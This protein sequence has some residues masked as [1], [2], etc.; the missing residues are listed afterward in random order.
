MEK[1]VYDLIG[2]DYNRTRTADP[3][4]VERL[5]SLLSPD[6][7]SSYLDVGCG[8]GNYTIA[9]AAKGY[10]M[11]GAEPSEVM[12]E[13]AKRKSSCVEWVQAPAENLPFE[14]EF[15]GGALATLTIHHWKSLE[16]GFAEIYRVLKKKSSFVIFTSFPEQ[17]E[18]YWL[19]HYFP[20]M[21]KDSMQVMPARE[22]VEAALD[23]AGF[24]VTVSERYFVQPDLKDLFLYSGKDRPSIYFD[25]Q[26]RKGIS[27]FS[28]LS[29]K[30]EVQSGLQKLSC[31][32][33]N[34]SFIK[35]AQKYNNALG[36][37]CFIVARKP[38]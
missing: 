34:G 24:T 3:F 13:E 14:N 18:G 23:S 19:N 15:F 6:K 10:S 36:D 32:L 20:N 4:L 29:N 27:S 7:N 30:E 16:K 21:L 35:T 31:D 11:Y 25:E 8:T 26:V 2:N 1:A 28:A 17:M 38:S 12:L 5:F 9:F 33:E 22:K 37:Y